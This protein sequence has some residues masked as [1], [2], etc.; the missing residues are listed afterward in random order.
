MSGGNDIVR[1]AAI[2]YDKYY[3]LDI[4]F[5]LVRDAA[6]IIGETCNGVNIQG[7]GTLKM[8]HSSLKKIFI[9]FT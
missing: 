7:G 4:E 2:L 9:F 8:S 6:P 5:R 3:W 1:S